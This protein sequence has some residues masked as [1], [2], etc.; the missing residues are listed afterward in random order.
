MKKEKKDER[1]INDISNQGE[2]YIIR[3][4]L[5]KI[6]EIKFIIIVVIIL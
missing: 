5:K 1:G 3:Q 4:N 6:N 2:L